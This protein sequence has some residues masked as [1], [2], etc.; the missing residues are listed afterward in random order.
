MKRPRPEREPQIADEPKF[1][2]RL[3]DYDY[4]LLIVYLR[5]LDA[6]KDGAH[7]REA[8]KIVLRIDPDMEPQRAFHAHE[9]HLARAHWMTRRGYCHLLRDARAP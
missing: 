6:E 2:D 8:A 9:T 1:E 5:L 7:W 4:R 3:T